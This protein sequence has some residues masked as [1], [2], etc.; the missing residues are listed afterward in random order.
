ME[1][2]S[3]IFDFVD[4]S[5]SNSY[6]SDEKALLRLLTEHKKYG[7][8]TVAYDFDNTV[9]DYHNE[10]HDYSPVIELIRECKECGFYLI[11]FT[12]EEDTNKVKTFLNDNDIPFDAINENPP[13]FKSN[14]RKIYS[15]IL[16][17]DRAGLYSAYWQLK[18]V[19][20]IIKYNNK[21]G[22][23]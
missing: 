17:D 18:N 15:N 23:L 10:G 2:I 8:L 6:L 22:V 5:K 14:S 11:V 20:N 21:Y 3:T 7:S 4:Y 12:G 19:V 16:L 9:Y 13:F 1:K